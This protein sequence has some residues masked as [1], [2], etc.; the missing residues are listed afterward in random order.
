MASASQSTA[1][2]SFAASEGFAEW[3]RTEG[4]SLAFTTYQAGKVC[5]LG[6]GGTGKLCLFERSFPRAMGLAVSHDARALL[7]A[8]LYEIHRFDDLLQPG[9]QD[10]EGHT[11]LYRPNQSWITG[12]LDVHDLAFDP[13]GQPL[14]VATRFSCLG[15]VAEGFSFRPIWKPPFVSAIAP[16]DRCHLNGMAMYQGRA[17]YVTLF[18]RSD[19][20]EGWR[21]RVAGNGLILDVESGETVA[22]GLSMP[23]SPR[24][25]EDTLYCLNSGTEEFGIVDQGDGSFMAIAACPGYARGLALRKDFAV[26]GL[27]LPRAH[28]GAKPQRN[29]DDEARC[30]IVVLSLSSG[31]VLHSLAIEGA[32]RELYDVAILPA[33]SPAMIGLRNDDVRYTLSIDAS[34]I[35]F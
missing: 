23:H 21:D 19:S 30:G 3:L 11:A 32:I 8:G 15:T 7:L 28:E 25:H 14:F 13:A 22:Q 12:E 10:S 5:L 33:R 35:G 9:Q 29:S 20:A 2:V 17:Q 31:A 6:T 16:D 24:L 26:I 18:A 34:A 4:I 27:S 1:S